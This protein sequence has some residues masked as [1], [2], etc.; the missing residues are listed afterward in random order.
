MEQEGRGRGLVRMA[1]AVICLLGGTLGLWLAFRYLWGVVLPFLLAFL[2][3]RVLRAPVGALC[4]KGKVDRRVA[5]AGVVVLGVGAV[6]VSLLL[7]A[8]RGVRELRGLVTSLSGDEGAAGAMDSILSRLEESLHQLPFLRDNEALTA[9]LGDLLRTGADRL[10]AWAGQKLP[11]AAVSAAGQLPGAMVFL[12]VLLLSAYYFTADDGALSRGTLALS[13]RLLPTAAADRL[14][15]IGRRFARLGREYGRACLS[16]GGLCFLIV[17]IGLTLLRVPYAF[18]FALFIALV[19]FLPL[20]GTGVVLIPF[21]GVSLLLG[22]PGRALGLLVLYG[23]CTLSRQLLEPRL[24][25]RGLGLHPL[26][27]L[28]VMYAGLRLFGLGGMLILPLV[29]GLIAGLLRDTE[30]LSPAPSPLSSPAPTRKNF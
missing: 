27:S 1:A 3:S 26:V 6:T 5:S 7:G 14:P 23:V 29:V 25:G 18:L 19:D 12:T 11:E 28:M 10:V 24:M 15:V 22:Q 16:L 8:R 21:A 13:R 17:F 2:L 9:S 4:R 30:D 20:L